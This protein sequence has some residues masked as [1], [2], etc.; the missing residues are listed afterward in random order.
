MNAD[1]GRVCRTRSKAS[2]SLPCAFIFRRTRS[3]RSILACGASSGAEVDIG[4]DAR[5]VGVVSDVPIKR[6]HGQS[7]AHPGIYPAPTFRWRRSRD[8]LEFD[9]VYPVPQATHGQGLWTLPLYVMMNRPVDGHFQG[10][11]VIVH[12]ELQ[13]PIHGLSLHSRCIRCLRR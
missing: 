4:L 2:R 7:P 1:S 6:C 12:R 5:S 13:V 11:G 3:N 10:Q 9:G 8:L